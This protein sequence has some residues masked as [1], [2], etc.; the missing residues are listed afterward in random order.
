MPHLIQPGAGEHSTHRSA[1]SL[2]DQTNNQPDEGLERGSGKTRPEHGKETGQRARC[3]GAGRHRRI[4]LTRTVNERSMLSSS[5][6]KT[7]EPRVTGVSPRT[8]DSARKLRNTRATA[9][10]TRS[11]PC[12]PPRLPTCTRHCNGSPTRGWSHVILDG[13]VFR[14]DRCADTTSSATGTTIHS[15]YSGK[16]RAFGGNVQAIMRPDGQPVWTSDV[17]AG[18]DHDLTAARDA[19]LLSALYWAASQLH[20]P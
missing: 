19:H 4:T 12:C 15:W 17:V 1:A 2:S 9:I 13:K 10:A 7:H 20:L 16:H 8:S 3:G 11:W 6:P 14:T 5:H 18:H